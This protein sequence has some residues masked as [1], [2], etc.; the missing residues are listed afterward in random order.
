M[1]VPIIPID[2][3]PGAR[4]GK[5]GGRALLLVAAALLGIVLWQSGRLVAERSAALSELRGIDADRARAS[6]SP[7]PAK[8]DLRQIALQRAT[9]Q[10]ASTLNTP[11]GGLLSS[12]GSTARKDVAL[13]GIEP[14]VA[15]RSVRL[16]AEARD[17]IEMLAYLAAL[18]HDPRLSSVVLASHQVQVQMPGAPVRFQIQAQWGGTP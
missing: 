11:W 10:V 7:L 6:A 2:F 14:S 15:K 17:D 1:N 9:R 8:S 4:R 12:L 5:R 3:A 18:Q 16:T 13:L